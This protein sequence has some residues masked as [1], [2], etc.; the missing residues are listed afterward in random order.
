MRWCWVNFQYWGVLLIWIMVGQG[1][2]ALAVGACGGCLDICF[3][4]L[5]FLFSFS[6]SL[7]DGSI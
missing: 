3:S 1:P 7:G 4:L 6:L 5:S 2:A